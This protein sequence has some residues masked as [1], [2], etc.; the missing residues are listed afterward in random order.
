VRLELIFC[1]KKEAKASQRDN[2]EE[3]EAEAP[4]PAYLNSW[5]VVA[6]RDKSFAKRKPPGQVV[7]FRVAGASLVKYGKLQSRTASAMR[8]RAAD[9]LS[10][11]RQM[12][13]RKGSGSNNQTV[14]EAV[15]GSPA[16]RRP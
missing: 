15:A 12:P 6:K 11:C 4:V 10:Q 7:T 14:A 1:S 2:E 9:C 3:L 13:R 5:I 16:E 8:K